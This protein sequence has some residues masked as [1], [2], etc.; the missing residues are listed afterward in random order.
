MGWYGN[1]SLR[2]ARELA[3]ET[4]DL[5]I[6]L[7]HENLQLTTLFEGDASLGAWRRVGDL[8]TDLLA[9]GLNREATYSATP[10]FLAECRRRSFVRAYYLDKVFAAVFNRPP[11]ITAR[12]ADCNLPL[13]LSDNELF[14]SSD[15]IEQAKDNL[16]QDGWNTDEEYRTATWARIRYI[17]AEFREETVE[18]Q[19]RS[20][21]P[22]DAIKLR[23]LSTRCYIA[24]NGLPHYLQYRQDCWTSN[25][26]PTLCHMHAKVY[27][28]Y[29]H[30]HFQV[31]RLLGNGDGNK[32]LQ[33]ELLE[34]SAN[35]LETVVQMTS[36]RARSSS[37]PRDLPGIILAYGLPC[38]AILS[39]ALETFFRDLSKGSHLLPGIKISTLIRNLSVL[40][41]QLETVSS[42][43][44]TN[45]VF[46]IK[47]SK[48]ISRKLDRI[49]DNFTTAG[50]T[51]TPDRL[52]EPVPTLPTLYSSSTTT[53]TDIDMTGFV[54]FDHFDLADWAINFDLG[55]MS[56]EWNMF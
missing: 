54:D 48:A 21:Q 55:T 1:L 28:S 4:T 37:S 33:P 45:H 49:L 25:L 14:T 30:I 39:T 22:T 8:A 15:K 20:I 35:M 56:D 3:P 44:E 17:L 52:L 13:D 2:L 16:T 9:L 29:L 38:A 27:L 36:C 53:I 11:R 18:Y 34:V 46:C 50:S 51:K 43:S 32:T 5:M 42:P 6:W 7:A 19:Y 24:W 31:Y 12:H 10:F 41:S 47:A 26:P 23:D 40:G